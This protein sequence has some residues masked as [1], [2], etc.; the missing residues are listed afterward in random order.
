MSLS[1]DRM[2]NPAWGVYGGGSA[3]PQALYEVIDDTAPFQQGWS[4]VDSL[5]LVSGR[6]DAQGRPDSEG[7]GWKTC[8]FSHRGTPAGITMRIINSGGGGYGDP[9][10]REP[11]RVAEDVRNELV[12]HAAARAQYGV[13]VGDDHRVDED[14][15]NTLRAKLRA[16]PPS[17]RAAGLKQHGWRDRDWF[18]GGES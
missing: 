8:K 10:D 11:W 18:S 12:S 4:P 9:L 15:T 1:C 6:H 3:L 5:R 14:A 16:E 2:R 13:V 7:D 17:A